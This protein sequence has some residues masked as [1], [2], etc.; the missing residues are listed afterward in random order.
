MTMATTTT[1]MK[2]ESKLSHSRT[3]ESGCKEKR[4]NKCFV[5]FSSLILLG[6]LAHLISTLLSPIK[7]ESINT[8][9]DHPVNFN[10]TLEFKLCNGISHDSQSQS[11]TSCSSPQH[12]D[13]CRC[14]RFTD[15]C[16]IADRW[17]REPIKMCKMNMWQCTAYGSMKS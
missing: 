9:N 12:K 8:D 11:V 6:M 3:Q 15:A 2:K 7:C 10:S 14:W 1:T 17:S 5:L 4:S 16:S 13:M